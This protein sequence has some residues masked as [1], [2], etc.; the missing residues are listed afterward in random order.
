MAKINL[1]PWRE[2]LRKQRQQEFLIAT[3]AGVGLTCILFGL[4]YLHIESLKDYQTQRNQMVKDEITMVEKR[5]AEIKDIEEKKAKLNEK[6]GLIQD[7]QASRPKIVHLFDELRKIT[8]VGIYLTNLS[9]KGSEIT[10]EGKSQ[11]SSRVSEYMKAIENST[12]LTDPKLKF[13]KGQSNNQAKDKEQSNDFTLVFKQQSD[14]PDDE[15][16]SENKKP[17]KKGKK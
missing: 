10:V 9:Q 8:P 14:K 1:L 3:G 11:S 15:D 12:Y 7:L 16:D 17:A 6:I 2:E 5:I 4:V 13:V